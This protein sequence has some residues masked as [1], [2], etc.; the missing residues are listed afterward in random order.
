[1]YLLQVYLQSVYL[2]LN[3]WV[4]GDSLLCYNCS[5]IEIDPSAYAVIFTITM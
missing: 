2:F 5:Q 1:M 4:D 3:K